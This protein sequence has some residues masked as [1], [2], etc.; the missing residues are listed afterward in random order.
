L[1]F[2]SKVIAQTHTHTPDC[3]TWIIKML[4][5]WSVRPRVRAF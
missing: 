4:L 2:R 1:A 5:K 3:S